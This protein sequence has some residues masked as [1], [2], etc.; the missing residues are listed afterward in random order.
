MYKD[1]YEPMSITLEC[2]GFESFTDVP[3]HAM[4]V[5]CF[6]SAEARGWRDCAQGC[7]AGTGQ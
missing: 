6:T 2:R 5:F 7:A 4:A 1:P 3:H